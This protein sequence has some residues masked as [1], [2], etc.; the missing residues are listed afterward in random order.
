MEAYWHKGLSILCHLVSYHHPGEHGGAARDVPRLLGCA[1]C[2]SDGDVGD[3]CVWAVRCW[4]WRN[5]LHD[6]Y[7][8]GRQGRGHCGPALCVWTGEKQILTFSG[9]SVVD[10]ERRSSTSFFLFH[11]L[12]VR[13][14]SHVHHR[15][16]WVSGGAARSAEPVG[17]AWHVGSG[18]AGTAW[19]Q[20]GWCQVDCPTPAA[21]AG[22]AGCL[23]AGLCHRHLYAPWSR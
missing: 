10:F 9:P 8:P 14:W 4:E 7:R 5:L 22:R 11:F 21:A 23:H 13:S 1:G 20:P 2:L 16:L 17:G 18:A 3:W 15:F 12:A 19:N 6:L